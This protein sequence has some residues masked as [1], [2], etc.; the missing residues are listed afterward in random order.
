MPNVRLDRILRVDWVVSG[1]AGSCEVNDPGNESASNERLVSEVEVPPLLSSP[2]VVDRNP[3]RQL[4]VVGGTGEIALA[5]SGAWESA[6]VSVRMPG[7]D[8]IRV[9][10]SPAYLAH[11]ERALLPQYVSALRQLD[12][13]RLGD[14]GWIGEAS[15]STPH[16]VVDTWREAFRFR[17][18]D[19]AVGQAGLRVPQLGAIHAVLGHWTTG[20]QV[21][22]T[23]VMPTGTGKTE[24]ML[25][26][27]VAEGLGRLLVIVPSDA[28]RD[29]IASKFESLGL[30]HELGVVDGAAVRPVVGRLQ[31]RLTSVE[32]AQLFAQACNVVV[33]TP[34]A[35]W[36]TTDDIRAVFLEEFSHLF[37]DEAHHV[38]AETWRLV[39][40]QFAPKPVVQ[41]TATPFREDGRHLGGRLLYAFPMKA[42]QAQGYFSSINYRSIVDFEDQD[43]AIAAAAV[44]QL[45]HDVASGLD[46]LI[47]ARV[48]R[49]GRAEEVLRIYQAVAPDLSPV[50]LHSNQPLRVRRDGLAAVRER[51]S[52][53]VVCV[54]MLGEGFD[55]PSLK[56][57]AIHDAHKSLGVTLQFVGRFARVSGANIGTATV[58]VG[59]P[60]R[61]YDVNLRRL[62]AE[63]ADWNLVV[64]DLS[65]S[66]VGIQQRVSDF[67]DGFSSLPEEV[68][69][70]NLTPKMS[71]VVYQVAAAW[72]PDGVLSVFPEDMLYTFPIALNVAERVAW[73]VTELETGV[74]WG[75]VKTLTQKAYDLY[76]LYWDESRRFLYINSSNTD[77]L[78]ED[79]AK[80]VGGPDVRRISGP[81]VYRAM[82]GIT[83]LVPTNVGV[84]DVVN[85]SRRF[86]MHVGADVTEGFP[87]AEAASKTKT[88]IFAFGY[89]NGERVSIGASMKGRLW[90]YRVAE[91]IRHWMDWCD[92]V[93]GKLADGS[94]SIAEV[95]QN[96]ICPEPLTGRP[97]LVPLSMELPWELLANVTDEV[98][99]DFNGERWPLLDSD[100]RIARFATDGPIHF[101]VMT[102]LWNTAY[103]LVLGNGVME[104]RPLSGEVEVVT[105]LARYPL[106]AY[107]RKHGVTINFE[108]DALVMP[109]GHLLQLK[110][111]LAPYDR[112][113]LQA[114][115]W[116][117]VDLRKESQGQGRAADSIQARVIRYILD[118]SGDEWDVVVDDDGPGE[119]ADVV[120][121]RI[122]D[123]RFI[124]R[125]HHC[126]Y[127]SAD[128]PGARVDD[129]YEVCGQAQKS[130]TARR[131]PAVFLSRLISREK[132][133]RARGYRSGLERGTAP[134]LY[135]IEDAARHLR[136]DFGIVIAQPG[137]S[138][139]KA[140]QSQ[141]ELL[142]STE[143]FL[144]ETFNLSMHVLCSA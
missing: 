109:P 121:L 18:E 82:S 6:R 141:L 16:E 126:K 93:G 115:D 84:L 33:T 12:I 49:I 2:L 58:V 139:G 86:S 36:S 42:A 132:R 117:G 127:S 81:T 9:L 118:E 138:K 105:R 45:R 61:D 129:L 65:E 20:A 54:D 72:D 100:L 99:L 116:Q 83:R 88:N 34:A 79:L 97:A 128:A 50:V 48:A 63:D 27:L 46:H 19:A 92:H 75:D 133:R 35:L 40:E 66:A 47:M 89:E 85:M 15:R 102:P 8:Q 101:S 37:I 87:A 31:H 108:R 22:A 23:V 130:V 136:P 68:T 59:R 32:N 95:M 44:D 53:I 96:F 122:T 56:V 113:L 103:E 137:L 52:R 1:P 80:A 134:D 110:R 74:D 107:L 114:L 70:R 119:L 62:Y 140:S 38:A 123:D 131:D 143:V 73:F 111:D 91:S 57:A 125:L 30:L 124:V 144:R 104:F 76:V 5:E 120:A 24:A 28:L 13:G 26:L 17:A 3:V 77:S 39:R 29:Q 4:L 43:R 69:L 51:R 142:A 106:S 98:S 7:G 71:T 60:D 21:P 112:S 10:R 94:I 78:H 41:F 11:G 25:G 90:S 55:L 135:K 14:L 67:E 64:R